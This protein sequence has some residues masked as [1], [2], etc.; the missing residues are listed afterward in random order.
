V[1]R[2]KKEKATNSRSDDE[3]KGERN[4]NDNDDGGGGKVSDVC[5]YVMIS[6]WYSMTNVT[7]ASLISMIDPYLLG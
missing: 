3:T 6:R 2:E 7:R 4:I 1:L 5:I